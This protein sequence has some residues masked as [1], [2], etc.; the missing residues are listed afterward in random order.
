MLATGAWRRAFSGA[1]GALIGI[2]LAFGVAAWHT[3]MRP[4]QL[5]FRSDPDAFYG[6]R[7]YANF[8]MTQ[9]FVELRVRRR[10]EELL[11]I[12]DAVLELL[13]PGA[14]PAIRSEASV[15]RSAATRQS[16]MTLQGRT[17]KNSSLPAPLRGAA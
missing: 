2:L 13:G 15:A 3:Q 8:L 16:S 14:N 6:N 11:R 12:L 4:P 17:P 1:L 7:W 5:S 9:I 10:D